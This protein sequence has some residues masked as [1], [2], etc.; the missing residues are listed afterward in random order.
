VSSL[1]P[2]LFRYSDAA[3]QSGET[4]V[5]EED[6][7]GDAVEGPVIALAP[8]KSMLNRAFANEKYRENLK[9]LARKAR[10]DTV[11]AQLSPATQLQ[12]WILI[13]SHSSM[14]ALAAEIMELV[15]RNGASARPEQA[16]R[17]ISERATPRR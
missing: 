3:H 10:P 8:L 2:A 12:K 9:R 16:R 6:P 14:T 11:L 15:S 5:D 1:F 17:K 4:R 13:G 7:C